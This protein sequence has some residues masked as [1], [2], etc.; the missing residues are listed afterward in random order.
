M[1]VVA[2]CFSSGRPLLGLRRIV[3]ARLW[4]V[5]DTIGLLRLLLAVFDAY[6]TSDAFLAL[7]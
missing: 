3:V 7:V 5:L 6:Q 4:L 1:F 2:L